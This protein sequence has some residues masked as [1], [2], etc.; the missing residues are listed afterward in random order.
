MKWGIVDPRQGEYYYRLHNNFARCS[1]GTSVIL[2]D[3]NAVKTFR[4]CGTGHP[5]PV[6]LEVTDL[7]ER[8][9]SE[10]VCK[11]HAKTFVSMVVGQDPHSIMML[12]LLDVPRNPISPIYLA[13][14]AYQRTFCRIQGTP[15]LETIITVE[16]YYKGLF[17]PFVIR[18]NASNEEICVID[19]SIILKDAVRSCKT[20]THQDIDSF[21]NDY[22][23][24]YG[25]TYQAMGWWVVDPLPKSFKEQ[26]AVST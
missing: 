23:Q 1:D 13:G 26:E 12:K 10:L 16:G 8:H 24:K 6:G 4:P 21:V 19:M 25:T 15:R 14:L 22:G 18:A 5:H 20:D 7:E 2:A 11:G 3:L 9:G 17:K